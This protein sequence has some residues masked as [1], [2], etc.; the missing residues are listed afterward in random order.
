MYGKAKTL[1]LVELVADLQ[2]VK[3]GVR[4]ELIDKLTQFSR[5]FS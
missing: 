2:K 3:R 4:T 5:E 1:A